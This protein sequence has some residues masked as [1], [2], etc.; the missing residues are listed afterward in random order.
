VQQRLSTAAM[1]WERLGRTKDLLWR[2]KQIAEFDDVVDPGDLLPRELAFVAASRAA[3]R[4]SKWLRNAAFAGAVAFGV[5]A[6]AGVRIH[7]KREL[8]QH[9]EDLVHDAEGTLADARRD[10]DQFEAARRQAFAS[11]DSFEREKGEVKWAEA[12]VFAERADAAYG[13]ASHQ[14]ETTLMVESASPEVAGMLGDVLYARALLAERRYRAA[15]RDELV[16]RLAVYDPDGR[17]RARFAAPAEL[18]VQSSPSGARVSIARYVE[19]AGKHR[20]LDPMGELGVTPIAH[21]SLAPGSYVLTFELPG[22]APT[23]YPVLLAR[24]ESYPIE[25]PLPEAAR[26]P[27]G[28]VYVAPGRFLF[29]SA[30]EEDARRAFYNTPP[31]HE[32]RTWSFLVAKRETTY[33]DWLEF[34]DGL[35]PEER[36]RRAPRVEGLTGALELRETAGGWQLSLQPTKRVYT[37]RQGEPI[38]YE[39]R[40]QRAV[41]DWLRFPVSGVS[42]EDALAYVRW[43]DATGRVPG[44]RLCTEHEWERAA[45]GADDRDYP[46][47]N[48]LDA[49]DA[50]I[51]QT[52]GK[53]PLAFGPDEVGS[54]PA[55]RSPFGVDD[56]C[57]NVF[58]WTASSLSL[59]GYVLRG[60]GYYY[61]ATTARIP[62]RQVPEPTIHDANLGIRVCVS[63]DP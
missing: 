39:G 34:L 26:V 11:F 27:E 14:L 10:D 36:A 2:A 4:R 20:R 15:Q 48:R 32:A 38:R 31:L 21:R 33:A 18:T 41:Q 24:G 57:G 56:M 12:L 53:E 46:H 17:R 42:P 25:V 22:R 8:E 6:V 47:G 13:R 54:H 23:T 30:A 58:E 51:D 16:E 28:F 45:R 43:L 1:E 5:G 50:D 19:V 49:D 62:N 35:P 3:L 61:D 60:G 59:E 29:G 52:Y 37:A 44:A 40:A 9:I 55:S 63:F 7:T